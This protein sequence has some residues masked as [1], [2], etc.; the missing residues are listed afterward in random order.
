MLFG[1][2]ALSSSVKPEL[3]AGPE[4]DSILLDLVGASVENTGSSTFGPVRT[5]SLRVRGF[6][7]A[8]TLGQEVGMKEYGVILKDRGILGSFS[9]DADD[10][11]PLNLDLWVCPVLRRNR[12]DGPGID[13]LV[14]GAVCE[15]RR[16]FRRVGKGLLP[17]FGAMSIAPETWTIV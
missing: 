12:V 3:R 10:E 15:G 14:L 16:E 8:I 6:L 1:R 4:D 11:Q 17:D 13:C 7:Y 9:C 5:A 2:R